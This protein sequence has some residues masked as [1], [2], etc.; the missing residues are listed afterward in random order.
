MHVCLSLT[1]YVI[2]KISFQVILNL[3]FNWTIIDQET[4]QVY[5]NKESNKLDIKFFKPSN[6][7]V[8]AS[9]NYQG[10]MFSSSHIISVESE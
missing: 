4:N 8:F 1:P 7:K 2:M 9:V 6:Y 10:S 3:M 5:V